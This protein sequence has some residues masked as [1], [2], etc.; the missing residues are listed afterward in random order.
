[1]APQ[2]GC[3]SRLVLAVAVEPLTRFPTIGIAF[4]HSSFDG[5]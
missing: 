4:M 5:A 3:T 2:V 1:M